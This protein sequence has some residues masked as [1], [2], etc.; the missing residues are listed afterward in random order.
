MDSIRVNGGAKKIEVNDEGE[1]I[2]LPVGD[3][4][5]TRDFYR[6][7]EDFRKR[8]EAVRV[9]KE[10]IAGSMDQVVGL[11]AEM[12]EK[13]D[14]LFGPGTCGKVFGEL[15]PGVDLLLDFFY[16][17]LPFFEESVKK[18]SERM[19]KYSARRTGSV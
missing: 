13:V 7:L 17:L 5:F 8:A 9:T 11:S 2:L 18:R 3:D 6:L 19:N 14:A 16:Q 12:K 10:D 1:F 15:T 4:G